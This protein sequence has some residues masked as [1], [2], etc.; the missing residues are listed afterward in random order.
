[1][2]AAV[3][4]HH[5]FEHTAVFYEGLDD[6]VARSIPLIEGAVAAGDA[7]LVTLNQDKWA[8]L[9]SALGPT[10]AVVTHVSGGERYARPVVALQMLDRFVQDALAAGASQVWSIG[11][12]ALDGLVPPPEWFRYELA[13]TEVFRH[14]PTR[15]VCLFDLEAVAAPLLDAARDVH[16]TV[17]GAP[18]PGADGTP[19]APVS[20]TSIDSSPVAVIEP[21]RS[22]AAARRVVR[23]ALEGVIDPEQVGDAELVVSELA[24][25]ALAHGRPPVALRVWVEPNVIDIDVS[26]R[27]DGPDDRL[28]GLRLPTTEPGG[29]GLWICGRVADRLLA[30]PT[31]RGWTARATFLRR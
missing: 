31:A 15:L 30:G 6:L 11:E 9:S 17:A 14:L 5:A 22:V 13:A 24:S 29:L 2:N 20:L 19:L 28:A 26:D 25:N 23:A 4:C 1:M 16:P 27:G 3:Q 8:R 18:G 10:A 12:L 21:L 7:V